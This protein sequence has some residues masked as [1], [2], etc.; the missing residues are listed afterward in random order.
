MRGMM[1]V[2]ETMGGRGQWASGQLSA[3]FV[4]AVRRA[5]RGLAVLVARPNG[6]LWKW[7]NVTNA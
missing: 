1:V 6:E 7:K 5:K 3:K 2:T 4:R